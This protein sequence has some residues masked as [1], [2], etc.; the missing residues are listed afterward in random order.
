M[1]KE[2]KE[3]RRRYCVHLRRGASSCFIVVES[4]SS[5]SQLK[6]FIRTP[7]RIFFTGFFF[8]FIFAPT[9]FVCSYSPWGSFLHSFHATIWIAHLLS[10][11]FLANCHL[12]SSACGDSS[13]IIFL[14]VLF[15]V[16]SLLGASLA[17][18]T[19]V[20]LLDGHPTGDQYGDVRHARYAPS[21]VINP[22]ISYHSQRIPSF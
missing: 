19:A 9:A 7:R 17:T 2:A 10:L 14:S 4:S 16:P 12:S 20:Y 3:V 18:Y 22:V 15:V 21:L 13:Q 11:L 8:P 1:K 5:S 6:I